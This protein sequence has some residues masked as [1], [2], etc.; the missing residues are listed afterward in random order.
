[1]AD[2]ATKAGGDDNSM[3]HVAVVSF[4]PEI[5]EML[6]R[7]VG[8]ILKGL[9]VVEGCTTE[10]ALKK[11]FDLYVVYTTGIVFRQLN[12]TI[13]TERIIPVDLF[14]MPQGIKRVL[15]LPEFSRLGVI[16][17]HIWDA[18]DLLAQ[19]LMTGVRNYSLCTGTVD[20]AAKMAVDYYVLPEE[21]APYV[22]EKKIRDNMVVIPRVLDSKSVSKIISTAIKTGSASSGS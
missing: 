22:K 18:S 8:G 13:E 10:Q 12:K 11:K 7:Y 5:V 9:A 14:P 21:I 15:M 6:H 16:A 1:M 2:R 19:L 17:G 20:N 3:I 4:R